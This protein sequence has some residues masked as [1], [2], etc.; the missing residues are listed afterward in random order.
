VCADEIRW[1]ALGSG[2]FVG[3]GALLRMGVRGPSR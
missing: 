2:V 1:H 3:G